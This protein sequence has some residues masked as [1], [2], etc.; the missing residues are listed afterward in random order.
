MPTYQYRC[1]ECGKSFERTETMTEHEAHHR[2]QLYLM[3]R[4][5]GVPTPPL[6]GLTEE[7]L[8]DKSQ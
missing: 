8:L 7:Q 1:R 5:L 3:L 6:Y 4:L 2:G